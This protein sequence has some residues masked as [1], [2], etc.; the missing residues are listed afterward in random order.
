MAMTKRE[1]AQLN[2][3]RRRGRKLATDAKRLARDTDKVLVAQM[4]KS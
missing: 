4:K 1:R 2:S 3:L